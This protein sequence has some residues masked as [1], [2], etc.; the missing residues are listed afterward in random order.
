LP[1]AGSAR[2]DAFSVDKRKELGYVL[3]ASPSES[4]WAPAM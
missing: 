2:D 4:S 1:V 3:S